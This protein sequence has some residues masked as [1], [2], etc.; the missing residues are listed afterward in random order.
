MRTVIRNGNV[1]DTVS[2]TFV[3]ERAV[4]IEDGVIVEVDERQDG[5]GEID[6][7]VDAR[8]RFVL[9]G[10]IDGHMHFRLATMNFHALASWSEVEFGIHMAALSRNTIE[11]GFTTV[12][13]LGGDVTGLMRAIASGATLGPRI[14]RAGRMLTQTGGH[15][16]AEGGEREVPAC[17]CAM[18]SSTFS[19]VAD[20]AEAVRKAARHNLREGSDFLKVHVSGGVASPSDPLDSVQYTPGELEA[21]VLEARHRGT[22]VAAHAYSAEAI[23][24][25]VAAGVHSI[26]HGNLIDAQTAQQL[27]DAGSVL[28][29]TLVTYE[30]MDQLG[31]QL[32][33]PK[34]NRD[35]NTV[36][37]EA[38]LASLEIADAAGVTMGLGT[39]LI[40]ETQWMQNRELAI[41]A[42]VQSAEAIL[43]SMWDTN[44]RL[45][46]LEGQVGV[47]APGAFGDIVVSNVN[48]LDDIA[49][50]AE[51]STSLSHVIQAGRLMVDR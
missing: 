24:Q 44:A 35:K 19:I 41:R 17:G 16:D 42:E 46:R 36:V 7:E 50:F 38:G 5:K 45:C 6:V 49:A 34:A 2:M 33:L 51:P 32:G 37:Y 12:R 48:P 29:P 18:R 4:V 30:A 26:E 40:G 15:G 8:G 31:E 3:G 14:V 10:L 27:A 22:Y 20:G 39:D 47:V 1:L 23:Q 9:P 25:A 28:V 13:D 43:R 21:A 11:R